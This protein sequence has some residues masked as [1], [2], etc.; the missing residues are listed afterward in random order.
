MSLW[1]RTVRSNSSSE[2]SVSIHNDSPSSRSLFCSAVRQVSETSPNPG[3]MDSNLGPSG[4]GKS[5]LARKCQSSTILITCCPE[6]DAAFCAVGALLDVPTHTVN[7][8]T[9][10]SSHDLWQAYSMNPYE[11]RLGFFSFR[12]SLN[13][14]RN[15]LRVLLLNSLSTTRGSD[16]LSS[17]M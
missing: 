11:V 7:M 13:L 6:V 14:F 9:L 16:V 17:L 2:F 5:L 3:L 15:Q 4:H 1:A 8:T 10:K 12:S